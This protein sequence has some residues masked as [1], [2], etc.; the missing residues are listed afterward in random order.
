MFRVFRDLVERCFAKDEVSQS[1]WIFGGEKLHPVFSEFV[2]RDMH[3]SVLRV[4][5]KQKTHLISCIMFQL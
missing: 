1:H 4:N 3:C 5:N 2:M